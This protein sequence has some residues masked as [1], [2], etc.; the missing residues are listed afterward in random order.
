VGISRAGGIT[1]V[2]KNLQRLLRPQSLAIVGA[3]KTVGIRSLIE[4]AQARGIVVRL[5][6]ARRPE[7]FGMHGRPSL[8]VL[9]DPIDAVLSLVDAETTLQV[10]DDACV[11]ERGASWS[12][13]HA[14]ARL[15]R[16]ARVD[17]SFWSRGRVQGSWLSAA[18]TVR[19]HRH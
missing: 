6:N 11:S 19:V 3:W 4:D 14:S 18:R 15:V 7:V 17:K 16:L 9:Q 2:S 10:V 12:L 8:T 1:L 5:V 13:R